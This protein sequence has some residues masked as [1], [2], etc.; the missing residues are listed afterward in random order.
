MT[1]FGPVVGL[2]G[3]FPL[4]SRCP[5]ATEPGDPPGRRDPRNRAGETPRPI[6]LRKEETA[7]DEAGKGDIL[8][9]TPSTPVYHKE[10][11]LPTPVPVL[12][13]EP[14]LPATLAHNTDYELE[15]R[16]GRVEMRLEPGFDSAAHLKTAVRH[17]A[18]I[19]S[20]AGRPSSTV[21]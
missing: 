7:E 21:A 18:S 6:L 10:A 14:L 3:D 15:T 13:K 2:V 16:H 9:F 12:H 8:P 4:A 5:H 11:L 19:V 1:S 17:V 20:A